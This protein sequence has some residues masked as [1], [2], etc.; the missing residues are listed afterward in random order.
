MT[1]YKTQKRKFQWNFHQSP[2]VK[3]VGVES[4][5]EKARETPRKK[6]EGSRRHR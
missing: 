5:K 3:P 2:N 1:I 4:E 6:C